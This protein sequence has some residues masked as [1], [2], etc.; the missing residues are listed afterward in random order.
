MAEVLS[1]AG[2]GYGESVR[3]P[4]RGD[5]EDDAPGA[6]RGDEAARAR[7]FGRKLAGRRRELGLSLRAAAGR[8]QGSLSDTGLYRIEAGLRYPNLRSLEVLA[9]VYGIRIVVEP[10]H[11]VG[12]E[13]VAPIES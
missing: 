8:T 3:G 7:E 10:G 1:P 9:D 13:P 2:R 12:I 6:S 11:R 5:H 4:P